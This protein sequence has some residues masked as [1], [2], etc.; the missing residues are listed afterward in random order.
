MLNRFRLLHVAVKNSS[1]ALCGVSEKII[2]SSNLSLHQLN[3][4]ALN[5][6]ISQVK[7]QHIHLRKFSSKRVKMVRQEELVEGEVLIIL[8]VSGQANRTRTRGS[9]ATAARRRMDDGEGSRCNLQGISLQ[10]LQRGFW[11]HDPSGTLG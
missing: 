2:N 6:K 10:K 11:F 3:R 7:N 5:P 8:V 4:E 1:R 9:F